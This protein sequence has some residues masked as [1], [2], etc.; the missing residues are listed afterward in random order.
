MALGLRRGRSPVDLQHN[1]LVLLRI[2]ALK[3]WSQSALYLAK[4]VRRENARVGQIA[5]GAAAALAMTFAVV[6]AAFAQGHF[7]TYS[8]PWA[9][10]IVFSYILKDRIKDAVRT[11]I[12]AM[13]PR[14]LSDRS[15]LLVDN[16]G[17]RAGLTRETVWFARL[18]TVPADVRD[19]RLRAPAPLSDLPGDQELG[20]SVIHYRKWMRTRSSVLLRDHERL[21]RLTA[22]IRWGVDGWLEEMDEAYS[23]LRTIEGERE[24]RALA[25]RVYHVHVVVRVCEEGTG[26]QV[27]LFVYRVTLSRDG[28]VR[29]ERL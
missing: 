7:A 14:L 20:E 11:I 3:R 10:I 6:A 28:I 12:G 24:A 4:R 18:E 5:A 25:R 15:H 16:T 1:E 17:G 9:F 2:R 19:A 8:L 21:D 23:I 13:I 26:G 22:L 27:G 29:T